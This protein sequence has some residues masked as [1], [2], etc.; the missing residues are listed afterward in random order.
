MSR[1]GRKGRV[2]TISIPPVLH[3]QVHEKME[4]VGYNGI[5]ELCRELL[6]K[7]INDGM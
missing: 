1:K 2:F 7:W 6:R 3:D 4:V 5:S